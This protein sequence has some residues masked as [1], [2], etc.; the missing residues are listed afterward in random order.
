MLAWLLVGLLGLAG[1]SASVIII[2]LVFFFK[3]VLAINPLSVLLQ[4]DICAEVQRA[5]LPRLSAGAH[6]HAV[7]RA[8]QPRRARP[9]P[10]GHGERSRW[11]FLVSKKVQI[12]PFFTAGWTILRVKA[13][14]PAVF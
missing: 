1:T 8:H 10:V 11:K 4:I 13:R 12:Q 14:C 9:E 2:V 5:E 3:R 6:L 7:R